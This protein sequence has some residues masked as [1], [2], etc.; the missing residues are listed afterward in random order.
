MPIRFQV[1]FTQTAK[2]DLRDI[3]DFIQKDS[4]LEAK[5]FIAHVEQQVS[6]LEQF[7]Q[8]CPLI[9]ENE[10]IG[11]DYRNLLFGDYRTIFQISNK[12][13]YVLRIIHGS[14]LLDDSMLGLES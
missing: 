2:N 3:W 7:P 4:P 10:S 9:P 11:K 13:V 8:R 14:R 1:E 12:T 5:K 6:H